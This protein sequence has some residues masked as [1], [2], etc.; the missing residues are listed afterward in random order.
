MRP[1]GKILLVYLLV[2]SFTPTFSNNPIDTVRAVS[3]TEVGDS[4]IALGKFSDAIP[5]FDS[6]A[7]IFDDH[8]SW[9]KF[10]QCKNQISMCQWRLGKLATSKELSEEVITLNNQRLGKEGEELAMAY[11]NL[12]VVG[13]LSGES[14]S[15]IDYFKKS[16]HVRRQSLGDSNDLV[17][18]SYGALGSAYF[19]KNSFDSAIMYNKLALGIS[20]VLF[21][22]F[23][24]QVAAFTNTLGLIYEQKGMLGLATKY[25]KEALEVRKKVLNPDHPAL[26]WSYNNVGIQYEKRGQHQL[27]MDHYQEALRIRQKV[28]KE[29]HID[30]ASSYIN[31][32][33]LLQR[34]GDLELSMDYYIRAWEIYRE[35]NA[36]PTLKATAL[37][38]VAAI[39]NDLEN[40]EKG[41][42]FLKRTF[43]EGRSE[44]IEIHEWQCNAYL[45]LG[46]A[47]LGL[48]AYDSALRNFDLAIETTRKVHGDSSAFA[49]S[50]F[51][52]RAEIYIANAQ[53]SQAQEENKLAL[54]EIIKYQGAKH[55][56]T[57]TSFM[58]L[59]RVSRL[60]NKP[61]EALR[62][63]HQALTANLLY[64]DDT[65]SYSIPTIKDYLGQYE[66]LRA[67]EAKADILQ[68]LYADKGV[69][70]LD[71]SLKHYQLCDTLIQQIRET[72]LNYKDKIALGELSTKI[73]E[74][75]IN[76]AL[77]QF[78]VTSDTRYQE[79]AFYFAEKSKAGEL[80]EALSGL[81]ARSFGLIPD[82][83]LAF[84][85]G[86]K[87]DQAYYKSQIQNDNA[88]KASDTARFAYWKDQLFLTN[89]KLDSLTLA[90]EKS[91]PRYHELKYSNK[92]F[93][94]H[95]V[96]DNLDSD[97][98]LL[99]YF[100]GDSTSY[101]F[102]VTIDDYQA[103]RLTQS[104]ELTE[105][106]AILRQSLGNS[107]LGS[108][109]Q[110]E[111]YRSSASEIYNKYLSP[112]LDGLSEGINK[113]IIIP[114][115]A[116]G[117]IPFD[118]LIT[119]GSRANPTPTYLIEKYRLQ[120]GYSS[121]LL[122][123]DFK[124]GGNSPTEEMIAFAPSY[125][126]G[127]P[128]SL[129]NLMF[130]KFRD[131][132]TSLQW[133][134]PEVKTISH[135]FKSNIYTGKEAVEHI[136]KSK[137]SDYSIVHLAMHALVD[138]EDAMN[139]R[140]V[141]AQEA[142]SVEDNF[143]HAYELYNM[144][145]QAEMAVL[146]A[147]ETGF[148]K[149]EK[150]EG[151]MSLARAFSY[152]GCPSVVMSHWSVNDAATSKLMGSFYKHLADG[153]DKDKA[154]QLAKLE[155]LQSSDEAQSNPFFWGSFVV[156]GNV[157]PLGSQ[158]LPPYYAMV[159]L[160]TI[161]LLA[162]FHKRIKN[163]IRLT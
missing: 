141:F 67:L 16:L 126:E 45:L 143:L 90:L 19:Y 48:K 42:E 85:K 110:L 2:L 96:R 105:D 154:M 114:D 21:G 83:L 89:R 30:L 161:V 101:V 33:S 107:A 36:H 112:V 43:S 130:G 34:T 31:L 125:K 133:T 82:E 102:S 162:I 69:E 121:T 140:L 61:D 95:R 29:P 5:Q 157:E 149:L 64:F 115:G 37:Q 73:Y 10:L 135:Y 51:H 71:V 84:E 9:S 152:A 54:Q 25:Y 52:G 22:E 14:N 146:S 65:S 118:I 57:S 144:E 128:D 156:L 80:T 132:I 151:I 158:N 159:L 47:Y 138:D 11:Y 145:L 160:I 20:R 8:E 109:E 15:S 70:A 4:L 41:V 147:C 142:D 153:T 56:T 129:R 74:G 13:S 7:R 26:A 75:A 81:S 72:H 6:A 79:M 53:L 87:A 91:Y 77:Q 131:Q 58:A 68:E 127:E 122:F 92:V 78:E 76:V 139:S 94:I 39:N 18:R 117:Y 137:A 113:L 98:A 46:G 28:F 66:L 103:F 55:P 24:R 17:A 27:A 119:N 100:I 93:D 40:Y 106:I 59:G 150:G 62:Y 49:V 155:Y 163:L 88:D 99:E 12:G 108:P 86:L 32:G 124:A 97:E 1:W 35:V 123:N 60:Q 3:M 116:L 104:K 111:I 136:F 44:E 38:N 148:G 120:Y 50:A 23:D 134:E 63:F